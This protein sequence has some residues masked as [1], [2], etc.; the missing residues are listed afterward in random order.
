[1]NT[2]CDLSV[3]DSRGSQNLSKSLKTFLHRLQ[4]HKIL[5]SMIGW[6]DPWKADSTLQALIS[7]SSPN[8]FEA[9][10]I[11]SYKRQPCHQEPHMVSKHKERKTADHMT[12]QLSSVILRETLLLW[13]RHESRLKQTPKFMLPFLPTNP[14]TLTSGKQLYGQGQPLA[15]PGPL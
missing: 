3:K 11:A 6:Y 10:P 13:G 12:F 2:C 8:V 1:M 15:E 4:F 7:W 14:I 9:G 5:A